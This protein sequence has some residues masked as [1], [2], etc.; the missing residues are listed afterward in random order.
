MKIVSKA[1]RVTSAVYSW[2]HLWIIKFSLKNS[3]YLQP[4]HQ[5]CSLF[6]GCVHDNNLSN[7]N[8]QNINDEHFY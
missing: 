7:I 6:R 5:R 1:E 2:C 8:K 4:F 3:K